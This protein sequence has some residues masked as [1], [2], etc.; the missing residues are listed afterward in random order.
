MARETFA[1]EVTGMP[2]DRGIIPDFMVKQNPKDIAENRDTV[3]Q[4][5]LG[6]IARE[7]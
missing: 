5:T 2:K 7:N 6:L 1:A 3:E 4:F